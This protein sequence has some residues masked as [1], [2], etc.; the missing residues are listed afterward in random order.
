MWLAFPAQALAKS[1]VVDDVSIRA[2]LFEDGS[3]NVTEKRSFDFKGDFSYVYWDFPSNNGQN[4]RVESVTVTNE[5]GKTVA[6][7]QAQTPQ[8]NDSF[9]VEESSSGVK[10]TVYHEAHD[11]NLTYE[12]K[13]DEADVVS[14]YSDKAHLYWQFIGPSWGVETRSAAITIVP[15]NTSSKEQVRA[16]AHGPLNG[17]VAILNNGDVTL[18]V[19]NLPAETFV[20]ARVLY[21]LSLFP[22][23]PQKDGAIEASVLSEEKGWANEANAQRSSIKRRYWGWS[24]LGVLGS[25]AFL[26]TL[27]F[28]FLKY[29]REHENTI[30]LDG[31]YW[32]DDPRPTMPPAM[33]GCIWRFGEVT[34]DEMTA[35]ILDLVD[36]KVLLVNEKSTEKKRLIGA[37]EIIKTF[38]FKVDPLTLEKEPLINKELVK[39]LV[40]TGWS[41]TEFSFESLKAYADKNASDFIDSVNNWYASVKA[42]VEVSGFIETA[43]STAQTIAW[44]LTGAGVLLGVFMF[45]QSCILAGV[46][47]LIIAVPNALMSYFMKRRSKEGD[48]LYHR[49][50]GIKNYLEDFS[51]IDTAPPTSIV[52]WNRYLVLATVFGIADKVSEQLKVT[53]PAV[54]TADE[55]AMSYW[56]FYGPGLH[57]VPAAEIGSAINAAT[58]AAIAASAASSAAGLGGGF[59]G[60]GGF[61]GG[62]GGGGAG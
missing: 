15:P 54:V 12:L 56:W 9:F 1:Y 58:T 6:L 2:Q 16:W 5:D 45:I 8:Q 13:Y 4:A 61:G 24:A 39:L 22:E 42:Q 34:E 29:G 52:I 17:N 38:D 50:Q 28:M 46:I 44:I 10:I 60:G 35:T 48:E 21:P 19:T 62:G 59:S 23:A 49:Y 27:I 31:K 25:I 37:P 57:S 47:A 11:E 33:V 55:F 7:Q 32:R 3:M 18:N 53:L 14:A 36:R 30:S 26:G 43:S 20:E 41:E 51:R 40:K